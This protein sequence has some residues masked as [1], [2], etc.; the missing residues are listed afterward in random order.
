[1][2]FH[3]Q[4]LRKMRNFKLC[5]I[6][7]LLFSSCNP[8]S[9]N[10]LRIG[11][12]DSFFCL[13]NL[14]Y[15][16]AVIFKAFGANQ[17]RLGVG[18]PHQC[19][20]VKDFR[21]RLHGHLVLNTILEHIDHKKEFPVKIMLY[22]VNIFEPNGKTSKE[23]WLKAIEFL[24]NNKV[25][26]LVTASALA[27]DKLDEI[28]P[29]DTLDSMTLIAASGNRLYPITE[30]TILF[31]QVHANP[32]KDWLIGHYL[33]ATQAPKG[34]K[35]YGFFDFALKYPDKVNYYV[36]NSENDLFKMSSYAVS[37]AVAHLINKCSKELTNGDS[38][39]LTKCVQ[40]TS[41]KIKILNN[42]N[43]TVFGLAH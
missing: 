1:M 37:R 32:Q 5:F 6:F 36:I 22:P 41:S 35:K 27:A 33:K 20:K 13:N 21:K 10:E 2:L 23:N 8:F 14:T 7:L 26:Y 9:S 25:Q 12:V 28:P 11:I 40:F 43:T 3:F 4:E 19:A 17:A 18:K 24:N 38:K 16:K 34:E 30:K 31:P 15:G 39:L 29:K 42:K